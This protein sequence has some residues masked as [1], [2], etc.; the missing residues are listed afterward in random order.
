MSGAVTI[1]NEAGKDF[2]ATKTIWRV[3]WLNRTVLDE[4]T[5]VTDLA[6]GEE[7]LPFSFIRII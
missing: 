3:C 7:Q 5:I 4:N 6:V 2:T 1:K